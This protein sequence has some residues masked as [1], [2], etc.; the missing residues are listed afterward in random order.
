MNWISNR[1]RFNTWALSFACAALVALFLGTAGGVALASRP[2]T[3]F[4][5]Q[6]MLAKWGTSPDCV[7]ATISTVDPSW[8][9]FVPL[10]IGDCSP[11]N[12]TVIVRLTNGSWTDTYQG[13]DLSPEYPCRLFSIPDAVGV[14]LGLCTAT[15]NTA[16]YLV[17]VK[18]PDSRLVR[19]P[20]SCNNGG[21]DTSMAELW[22]LKSIHWS[23]WSG[24]TSRGTAR[25]W[26]SHIFVGERG[27]PVTIEATRLSYSCGPSK[28]YYTR[29]KVRAKAWVSRT[30]LSGSHHWNSVRLRAAN[31]TLK[32]YPLDG[33]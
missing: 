14:D 11:A 13:S 29:I 1:V 30:R 21:S 17:C 15:S 18:Y 5:A 4:E 7:D 26:P 2:A 8:G 25:L 6:A 22:T 27:R 31:F 16:R 32:T 24:A 3:F 10:N 28:P 12:G 23:N 19:R 33:C 9:Y 20:T